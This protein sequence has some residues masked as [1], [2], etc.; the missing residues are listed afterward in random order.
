MNVF[1]GNGELTVIGGDKYHGHFL[2]GF[3]NG[4]G[5]LHKNAAITPDCIDNTFECDFVSSQPCFLNKPKG[6]IQ[7]YLDY[8]AKIEPKRLCDQLLITRKEESFWG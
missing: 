5:I 1:E 3:L 8:L 4:S 7:L 6:A 2:N